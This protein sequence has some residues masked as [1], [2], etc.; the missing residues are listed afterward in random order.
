M[1]IPISSRRFYA[2]RGILFAEAT[3]MDNFAALIEQAK[4]CILGGRL[5][6]AEKSI[7]SLAELDLTAPQTHN[8]Y[9]ILL[10]YRGDRLRALKHY[11]AATDLD[12]TYIPAMNNLCRAGIFIPQAVE[13][14]F[15]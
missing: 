2:F 7:K 11:R 8:L 4:A 10:E 3:K 1:P 14:D 5:E 12:P 15:G 6:E 13:L 9:G